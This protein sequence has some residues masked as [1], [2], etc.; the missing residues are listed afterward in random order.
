[1][2][3]QRILL[4]IS[5]LIV[6]YLGIGIASAQQ[7]TLKGK[8][9]N[10]DKQPLE[11]VE[12]VLLK[13]DTIYVEGIATDSTG[14]FSFIADKGSYRLVLEYFGEEHLNEIVNLNQDLDLGEIEI[15]EA[16]ALEEMIITARKK[17]IERKVDRIV[18]NLENSISG[19]SGNAVDALNVTPGVQIQNDQISMIGK[20]NMNVMINDRLINLSGDDL[21]NFLRNLKAE[22]IKNIEVITSP[23]AKYD[24]QGNSGLVNIITKSTREDSYNGNVKALL[25]QSD[26]S[27]GTISSGFNYN[28]NKLTISTSL[29]YQNGSTTPYQKYSLHY[30]NYLWEE[31]NN[32]TNYINNLSGRLAV[33][34]KINSKWNI[35]GEYY[36]SYSEPLIKVVN[37]SRI[38]NINHTLDS[39]II[40]NSRVDIKRSMN[41]LNMYSVIKLDTLGRKINFDIDYVDYKSS[42]QNSFFSNSYFADGTFKPDLYFSARN[43]GELDIDIIT[44]RLDV[45]YPTLW[46]NLNFG[47][48]LT[49]IENNSAVEFYN[50]TSGAEIIDPF[51]TNEFLYKEHIQA[52][53]FSANRKL[54]DNLELKM[55][56][57]GEN[58]QIK[59]QSL[60]MQETNKDSYFK[61]FPTVYLTYMLT[62][63]KSVSLSYN[64]RINRPSYNNLNPFRFYSTSFNY[65][66][67]NPFLNAYI[68][69]NLELSYTSRNTF[70]TLYGT[71]IN[72]AIDQVTFVNNNNSIQHVK[73]VNA[74]DQYTIGLYHMHSFSVG[75]WQTY[76]DVT[77][78][79][80]ESMP[81]ISE[82]NKIQV[83]SGNIKTTNSFILDNNSNYKAELSYM[84]R[85]PSIAGSYE[86]SS[87]SQLNL[88]FRANFF[89]KKLLLTIEAIDVL[90]TNK[91]TFIQT[92]NGVKQENYDYPDLRRFNISLVYNF[93]KKVNLRR[94]NQISSEEKQRIN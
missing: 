63:T 68:T 3:V 88:A 56:I 13:N 43:S 18:F 45:E 55:G 54:T 53:Y 69:N 34:Y 19:S 60:T 27:Y 21:I 25:S 30:P 42:T 79:Y 90:K 16:V 1:M 39:I 70:T 52:L 5:Y 20:S 23:P 24:A 87:F 4:S 61:L 74:Y 12:A 57:R 11:F 41:S 6:M 84:Y 37:E 91:Q 82:L 64:K 67:G 38:Y 80:R 48:K 35:G 77:V 44:S 66:E 59:G 10:K 78:F 32:K 33:D 94:N 9:V 17:L 7:Q 62:D 81:Q 26:H 83:W 75:R 92:V 85:L 36:G 89:D 31:E 65:S 29:N 72:N 46:A 93:G 47:A 86:I 2:I 28:K 76:N 8:V 49:F 51:N 22:D 40:N 71:L 14:Y 73:P 15:D 58:T 50:T